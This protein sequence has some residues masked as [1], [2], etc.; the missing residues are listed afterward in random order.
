VI[1]ARYAAAVADFLRRTRETAVHEGMDYALFDTSEAPERALR[2]YLVRR[3]TGA[4]PAAH[5]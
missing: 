1:G 5:D 2:D 3:T 4:R